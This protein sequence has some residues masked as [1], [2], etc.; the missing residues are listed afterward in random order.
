MKIIFMGT[1]DFSVYSLEK[2]ADSEEIEILAVV[3]QP[4][5]PR[6]RGQK[7]TY[8]PV[9]KKA[10]ELDLPVLQTDNINKKEFIN[11]LNRLSPEAI[12][13]VAFGQKLGTEILNMTDYGCINLHG[14]LLPEYRGASPIHQAILDGKKFTGITTMYM[15]EGWDTGDMIY[16]EKVEIKKT[17]TVGTLH[18]KL[19]DIG[20]DLLVKTLINI[21]KGI[22]PR[23]KQ[24]DSQ[25]TH[26]SKIDKSTGKIDWSKS[27]EEIYN[28][29][30]G[31]N[32]WPGAYTYYQ[33]DLL[34]IWQVEISEER[35]NEDI[36]AGTIIKSDL[37]NGII[38]KSGDACIKI[39]E[40]Q[41]SGR[42]RMAVE[43][44]LHGSN[45]EIGEKLG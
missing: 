29:V 15:A 3:T 37:E 31:V 14:S 2:L 33:G 10:L 16:K 25:A 9:K 32:P 17:D 23:E 28:L 43:K 20:A 42:K 21:E 38:V 34:K 12:V 30:R 22:A 35:V 39:T 19:A 36:E 40:L 7:I 1:P 44:F 4:D 18:D 41:I 45:I 11:K 5:K 6:N 26:T 27:S 24:D 8:S 13:V